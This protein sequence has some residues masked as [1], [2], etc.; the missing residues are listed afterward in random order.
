[1][2]ST[3]FWTH[4]PGSSDI[5]GTLHLGIKSIEKI[6]TAVAIAHNLVRIGRG[7]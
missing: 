5:T 6:A 7:R 4:S 2:S 1:M 3:S